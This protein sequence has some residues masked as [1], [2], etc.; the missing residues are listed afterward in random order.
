MKAK[1]MNLIKKNKKIQKPK[2]Y[3]KISF[4]MYIKVF[5]K[6]K[7]YCCKIFRISKKY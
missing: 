6:N 4:K 1:A 2:L 7:D 5:L 3:I